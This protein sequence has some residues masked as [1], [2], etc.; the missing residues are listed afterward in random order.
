MLAFGAIGNVYDPEA[1]ERVRTRW[2]SDENMIIEAAT[3]LRLDRLLPSH[4]DMWKGLTTEPTVL[5]NHAA[6]FP[7]PERLD[8]VEV[9]DRVEL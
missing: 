3:E 6:G 9:G 2:Y 4:W 7:Y 1:D 5:H 8:I